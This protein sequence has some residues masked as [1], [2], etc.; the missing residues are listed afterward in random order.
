[1]KK[2]IFGFL[3]FA[4]VL[5]PFGKA[6]VIYTFSMDTAPLVG[7]GQ[8]VLD[9]QLSDGSGTNDGNNT[10]KLADFAFGAGSPSGTGTAT[11]GASGSLSS[12][13]TLTDNS[14]LNDY[15]ENFTPGALLSFTIDTTN[16]SDGITP[17]LFTVAIL[18][19]GLNELPTTGGASEFVD[20]SLTGGASP[21]VA[22]FESFPG[23][24]PSLAAPVLLPNVPQAP[25]PEPGSY[26]ELLTILLGLALIGRVFKSRTVADPALLKSG[27]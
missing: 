13:V 23:S 22:A 5:T 2:A 11:G 27:K 14:F 18:D 15:H 12:G 26:W 25:V 24:T 3:L 7:G 1:M 8:F 19:T 21:E 16:V 20:V 4:L 9:L 17:D 10:V 6:D